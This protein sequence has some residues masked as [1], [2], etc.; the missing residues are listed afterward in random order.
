MSKKLKIPKG[1]TGYGYVGVWDD[2]EIGWFMPDF[3]D[4]QNGRRYPSE[5]NDQIGLYDKEHR[6]FLCEITVTPVTDKC[7]RPV[8]RIVK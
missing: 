3:I 4:N 6:T 7:G 8:T 2:G 5:P 1:T